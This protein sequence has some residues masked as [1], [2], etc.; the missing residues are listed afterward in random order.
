VT[1]TINSDMRVKLPTIKLLRF[2][3]RIEDWKCFSDSFRSIIH[4]KPNLSDSEKFQ[5]LVSSISGDAAKII[6]SIELTGRNYATA[7][8]LLQQRYDD[9]R[10][11][12]KKQIQCL[13][14]IPSVVKESAKAF[15]DLMFL[16]I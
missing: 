5:Y 7:W 4:D 14:A 11:L 16:G 12:K 15:R 2:E 8:E 3:G 1:G 9:S 10:S 13:F 6:E